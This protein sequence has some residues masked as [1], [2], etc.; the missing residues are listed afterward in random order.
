MY[1]IQDKEAGNEISRHNSKEENNRACHQLRL[2]MLI[3]AKLPLGGTHICI[4]RQRMAQQ[5][6]RDKITVPVFFIF[7]AMILR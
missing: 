3:S 5:G 2:A 7:E 6:V 4:F 1:V